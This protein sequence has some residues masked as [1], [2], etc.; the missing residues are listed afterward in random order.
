DVG[1]FFGH[2]ERR[3]DTDGAGAASEKQDAAFEG[4]FQNAVALFGRSGPGL[5]IGDDFYA[6]HEATAADIAHQFVF[7]GPISEAL[8]HVVAN[9]GGVFQQALVFDHVERSE[10]SGQADG[11]A[12]EGGGVG[13]GDPVHDFGAAH[14]DAERHAGGNALGDAD[15]IGLDAG[16]LDGP[17]LSGAAR[18]ALHF[19][20]NQQN[21]VAVA[22]AA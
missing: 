20:H 7:C 19:V 9:F 3:G 17:P 12:S 21:S 6:D 10:S 16:M 11:I 22:D 13:A 5:F 15:D 8:E 18:A 2:D 1:L 14:G 4:E